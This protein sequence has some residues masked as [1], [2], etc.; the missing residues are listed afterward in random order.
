MRHDLM[1]KLRGREKP[2]E[3]RAEKELRQTPGR[4]RLGGMPRRPAITGAS[5]RGRR[6]ARVAA[7]ERGVRQL[8]DTCWLDR[9]QVRR[10]RADVG[11]RLQR[12]VEY[13][14]EQVAAV[15]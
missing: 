12:Q 4:T 6:E 5:E 7:C 8:V 3:R 11:E 13:Y 10:C 14:T 2:I 15:T 1:S 9:R